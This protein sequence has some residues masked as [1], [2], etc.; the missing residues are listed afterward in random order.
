MTPSQLDRRAAALRAEIDGTELLLRSWNCGGMLVRPGDRQQQEM[1]RLIM[2]AVRRLET[3][4][5]E[6]AEIEALTLGALRG[7]IAVQLAARARTP[8]DQQ[9]P[10]PPR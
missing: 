3:M 9:V 10:D 2:V 5:A 1:P 8:D 7:T 6:L 4:R